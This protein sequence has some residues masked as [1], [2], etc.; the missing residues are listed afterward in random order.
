MP[1][2]HLE[3]AEARRAIIYCRVSTTEQADSGLGL[4]AQQQRCLG[5]CQANGWTVDGTF[6]DAGVSASTLNRP[7]LDKAIAALVPG[8]VLV[9][10]KLD[11]LTRS[12]ADL[13][14]LSDRIAK[15]GAEWASVQEKFDTSSATGRL[16]LRLILELSQWERE[17]IGERTSA[18]LQ[19]KRARK[20]RLGTTPL[21][22]KTLED[23][24]VV[25]DPVGQETIRRIRELRIMGLSLRQ[26]AKVLASEGHQTARGG[27]WE[28]MTVSKLLKPRYLEQIK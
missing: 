6:I 25:I 9:V 4:E 21:G 7:E 10:L 14:P 12:V 3:P 5:Y 13:A 19:Q 26:I 16:M 20:E 11:R 15:V 22:F 8:S 23:G 1:K 27:K 18:A 17:I 28:A 24:K 2:F